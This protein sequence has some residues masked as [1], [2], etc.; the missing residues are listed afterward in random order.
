[1]FF[2]FIFQVI[3]TD[4]ADGIKHFLK[5]LL[6]EVINQCFYK[7]IYSNYILNSKLHY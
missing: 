5:K 3:S 7:L 1:M 6:N 4:S 2:D